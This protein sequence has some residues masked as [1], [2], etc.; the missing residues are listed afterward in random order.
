MITNGNDMFLS[1]GLMVEG[2]A[3]KSGEATIFGVMNGRTWWNQNMCNIIRVVKHRSREA[4][5][6]GSY[7]TGDIFV[8]VSER[9][10]SILRSVKRCPNNDCLWVSI[11]NTIRPYDQF[12]NQTAQF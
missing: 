10:W 7:H 4:Y 9:R 12:K 5:S 3:E 1:G 11:R 6:L 8:S 2:G